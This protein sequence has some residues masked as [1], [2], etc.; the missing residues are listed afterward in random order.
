MT[1]SHRLEKYLQDNIVPEDIYRYF[2]DGPDAMFCV[3][4]GMEHDN[5]PFTSSENGPEQ[6]TFK[7]LDCHN[8]IENHLIR[9]QIELNFDVEKKRLQNL[10]DYSQLFYLPADKFD[11]LPGVKKSECCIF[12]AEKPIGV[13][14][15][16]A[17]PSGDSLCSYGG[18]AKVCD[19]CNNWLLSNNTT[20]TNHI[21]YTDICTNCDNVYPLANHEYQSRQTLHTIG[22]HA[23]PACFYKKYPGYGYLLERPNCEVCNIELINDLTHFKD[24]PIHQYKPRIYCGVCA[25]ASHDP[26]NEVI[27]KHPI[28]NIYINVSTNAKG[29]AIYKID[30]NRHKAQIIAIVD[31]ISKDHPPEVLAYKASKRVYELLKEGII[32]L[33]D[34]QTKL[35]L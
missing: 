31:D 26:R 11:Y 8:A 20:L 35:I 9:G 21:T 17:I 7:C 32:P 1:L 24:N 2:P 13:P 23:C 33:K 19:R 22:K 14:W 29:Y 30:K 25:L 4:C 27:I 34:I 16:L 12:C 10:R 28:D 6:N 3:F 18:I 5:M 15:D